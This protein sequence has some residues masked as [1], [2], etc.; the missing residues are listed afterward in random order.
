MLFV[1]GI[2]VVEVL[3]SVL[4]GWKLVSYMLGKS[5]GW[6]A[7]CLPGQADVT[8]QTQPTQSV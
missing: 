1:C 2:C 8:G 7:L 3:L 6:T 4:S 5:V